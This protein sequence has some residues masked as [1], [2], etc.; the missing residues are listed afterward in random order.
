MAFGPSPRRVYILTNNFYVYEL[1][2]SALNDSEQQL[3]LSN[4]TGIPM[5]SK[6]PQ[7]F[8]STVFKKNNATKTAFFYWTDTEDYLALRNTDDFVIVLNL[9]NYSVTIIEGLTINSFL[10]P[11]SGKGDPGVLIYMQNNPSCAASGFIVYSASIVPTSS[12]QHVEFLVLQEFAHSLCYES[13]RHE[14]VYANATM[15]TD[16]LADC[17]NPTNFLVSTGFNANGLLYIFTI[18]QTV[19]LIDERVFDYKN[20][21]SSN[22]YTAYPYS[23]KTVKDFFQCPQAPSTQISVFIFF[24]FNKTFPLFQS[25]PLPS[26]TLGR[27]LWWWPLLS[28]V[29]FVSLSG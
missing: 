9:Q 1:P 13:N 24:V 18:E 25:L 20:F 2:R 12:S 8:N 6:W 28:L 19:Y 11:L 10:V 29:S 3:N 17:R 15:S 7:V 4:A 26:R 23:T 14:K 16:C 5:E 22:T 27:N 21:D